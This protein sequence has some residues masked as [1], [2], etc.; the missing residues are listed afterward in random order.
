MGTSRPTTHRQSPQTAV[1]VSPEGGGSSPLW[2]TTQPMRGS[3]SSANETP[4]D[5]QLPVSSNG[6]SAYNSGLSSIKE[7]SRLFLGLASCSPLGLCMRLR[8]FVVPE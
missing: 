2:A 4:Q 7:H 6:L 1:S 8:F 5:F 3:Y